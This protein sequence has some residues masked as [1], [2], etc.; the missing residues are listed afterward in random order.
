MN[1][2]Q[3]M[4]VSSMD[5]HRIGVQMG[6]TPYLTPIW[7]GIWG[8][9]EPP[10]FLRS[11]PHHSLRRWGL[12]PTCVQPSGFR[13]CVSVE[14][15]NTPAIGTGIHLLHFW[16]AGWRILVSIS[17]WTKHLMY[18]WRVIVNC[19]SWHHS[20]IWGSWKQPNISHLGQFEKLRVRVCPLKVR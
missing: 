20:G 4:V 8:W 13:G 10:C 17:I 11:R 19:W 7:W 5:H 14:G 6:L 3:R 2:C 12:V 15:L 18:H 1:I 16:T 9:Y